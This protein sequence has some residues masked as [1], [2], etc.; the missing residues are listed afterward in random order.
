MPVVHHITHD[1]GRKYVLHPGSILSPKDGHFH[2]I[3]Y[4]KL[5]K[6]YNLDPKICLNYNVYKSRY[7]EGMVHLYPCDNGEYSIR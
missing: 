6:L 5:I 1:T 7:M 2:K 4:K 3:G